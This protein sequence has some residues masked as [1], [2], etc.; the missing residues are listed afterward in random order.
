MLGES[1]DL[2]SLVFE[3]VLLS[4]PNS[5]NFF[6]HK[7]QNIYS[8]QQEWRVAYYYI[9]SDDIVIPVFCNNR[10]CFDD[11]NPSRIGKNLL[12][13]YPMSSCFEYSPLS[14]TRYDWV[15]IATPVSDEDKA[16]VTEMWCSETTV[17]GR[18]VLDGKVFK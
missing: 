10:G 6:C 4:N 14:F 1:D 8:K 17:E 15:K 16:L 18:P 13:S 11:L 7:I 2:I 9:S 5:I 3:C 12:K